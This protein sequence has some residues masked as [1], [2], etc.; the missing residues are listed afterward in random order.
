MARRSP[1]VRAFGAVLLLSSIAPA[2]T[3]WHVDVANCP[4][5]GSGTQADPFCTIQAGIDA[6]GSGDTVLILPGTY[7]EAIDFIGKALTVRSAD[8]HDATV[9]N[10]SGLNSS[11]VKCV[12]GE[13]PDTVLQGLTITGGAAPFEGGGMYIDASSP[14]VVDCVFT[15]NS[16]GFL[17]G[18]MSSYLSAAIVRDCTFSDNTSYYLG[19]GMANFHCTTTVIDCTFEANSVEGQGGGMY[20]E[21]GDGPTVIGCTFAENWAMLGGGMVN[22]GCNPTIINSR[23]IGN[24]ALFDGAALAN[25]IAGASVVN[26]TFIGNTA[27]G[28][29]GGMHSEGA[30]GPVVSNCIFYGNSAQNGGGISG[31]FGN[32][33]V[34]RNSIL[35]D[36]TP[37]QIMD[38]EGGITVLHS[39]VQG[40]CPGEGNI[41]VNP[42]CVDPSVG[43]L[44][45]LPSS[46]CIDT[47][48]ND[49]VP[50]DEQDL[51]EDGDTSELLPID[52][53]GAPRFVDGDGDGS[54]TVDMGAYEFQGSTCP[55]DFDGDGAVGPSD[56]ANLL[57]AWGSNPNH[58]ADL[59]GDSAVGAFDLAILLGNW[60]PCL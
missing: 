29:G 60:G 54:I 33:T 58:P 16:A 9:I 53:D 24:S 34:V 30:P 13:G 48:D 50:A 59:D 46:P 4:G 25:S 45:L 44:R 37:D 1:I 40:G 23:F 19:A 27:N 7:Y 57:G 52:L 17:G 38:L 18:G 26:C 51:D 10:A 14:T 55:A 49:A 15:G 47:G 39:D 35:W 2:E 11:V 41:N 12:N 5:P 56:L 32:V 42:L 22:S 43:N 28:N 21:G 36:N 31:N 3:T 8:G 20:N 6:A